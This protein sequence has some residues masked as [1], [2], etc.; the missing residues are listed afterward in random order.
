MHINQFYRH[1]ITLYVPIATATKT[2]EELSAV[3]GT[4]RNPGTHSRA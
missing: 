3:Y 4:R 1:N 2:S